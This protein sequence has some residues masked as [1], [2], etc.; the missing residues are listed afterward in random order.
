MMSLQ[1]IGSLHDVYPK[2]LN[3]GT[4]KRK[5]CDRAIQTVVVGNYLAYKGG[6]FYFPTKEDIATT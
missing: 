3:S 4:A 1:L 6:H 5:G 2:I